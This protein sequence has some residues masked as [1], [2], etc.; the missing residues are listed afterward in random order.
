MRKYVGLLVFLVA[1]FVVANPVNYVSIS[2]VQEVVDG[3]GHNVNFILTPLTY[4]GVTPSATSTTGT[5]GGLSSMGGIITF[6]GGG[7]G[8]CNTGGSTTG[9]TGTAWNYEYVMIAQP[10][11]ST[12]A[13]KFG[14]ILQ[15]SGENPTQVTGLGLVNSYG[16]PSSWGTPVGGWVYTT[17]HTGDQVPIKN[18]FGSAASQTTPVDVGIEWYNGSS[19]V[20]AWAHYFDNKKSVTALSVDSRKVS[21]QPNIAG[22]IPGDQRDPNVPFKNANFYNWVYHGGTFVGHA[23]YSTGDQ[24]GTARAQFYLP[25]LGGSWDTCITIYYLTNAIGFTDSFTLQAFEPSQAAPP[26]TDPNLTVAPTDVTWATRWLYPNTYGKNLSSYSFA[27]PLSPG[28]LNF[29]VSDTTLTNRY[30]PYVLLAMNP[31]P[32]ATNPPTTWFYFASSWYANTIPG[33]SDQNPR[34]WMVSVGNSL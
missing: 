3:D 8:G 20:Y 34:A 23:P 1:G 7:G 29:D 13:V 2:S 31:E 12:Q 10:Q 21:G 30:T 17:V 33:A 14:R 27:S 24:S 32:N 25:N 6:N 22:E 18:L 19:Y 4:G 5:S 26:N 11:A 15:E 9:T 16:Y 28:Y